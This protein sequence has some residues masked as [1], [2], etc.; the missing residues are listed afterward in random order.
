V[1]AES[2]AQ[3]HIPLRRFPV[4]PCRRLLRRRFLRCLLAGD[5]HQHFLLAGSRFLPD[6]FGALVS[7]AKCFHQVDHVL[8]RCVSLWT[9]SKVVGVYIGTIGNSDRRNVTSLS[10]S[11]MDWWIIGVN[12]SVDFSC[13]PATSAAIR[14]RDPHFVGWLQVSHG[15]RRDWR[16]WRN[17]DFVGWLK[18]KAKVTA[19]IADGETPLRGVARTI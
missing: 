11:R 6:F 10:P 13:L 8:A 19:E 7:A 2:S 16:R 17:P 5:R 12:R 14:W 18:V 4:R 9:L 1:T 3:W 15:R